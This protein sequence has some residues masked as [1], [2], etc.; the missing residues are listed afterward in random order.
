MQIRNQ[1]MALKTRKKNS[2]KKIFWHINIAKQ[3]KKRRK[4]MENKLLEN[5]IDEVFLF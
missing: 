4:N 2:S 5:E 1:K 3:I